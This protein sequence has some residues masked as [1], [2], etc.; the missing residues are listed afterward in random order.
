MLLESRSLGPKKPNAP[1]K[2]PISLIIFSGSIF[3]TES[4]FNS[5]LST[6]KK[7]D[8]RLHCFFCCLFQAPKLTSFSVQTFQNMAPND[9]YTVTY[10][11]RMYTY[12][13]IYVCVYVCIHIY[14][15]LYIY[16]KTIN[17]DKAGHSESLWA[18]WV[19]SFP[20]TWT[21][22][23]RRTSQGGHLRPRAA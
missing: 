19:P 16:V 21:W 5:R 13:Y 3:W 10:I 2:T 14:I 8:V 9:K 22:Q 12:I 7:L 23:I 11:I 1:C 18:P 17:P 20:L 6:A 4:V 15:C